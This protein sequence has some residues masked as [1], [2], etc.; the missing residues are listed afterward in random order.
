MPTRLND[1]PAATR[2]WPETAFVTSAETRP[3]PRITPALARLGAAN[4]RPFSRSSSPAVV[5]EAAPSE[6]KSPADDPFSRNVATP[7]PAPPS[8]SDFT[9]L[10]AVGAVTVSDPAGSMNVSWNEF[11]SIAWVQL[12]SVVHVPLAGFVQ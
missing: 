12:A 6:C 10:L 2:I 8:V 4:V 3:V 7:G 11:G 1:W 9:V 5:I